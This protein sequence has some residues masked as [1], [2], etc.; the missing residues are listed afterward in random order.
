LTVGAF[1]SV[2]PAVARV[3]P[4]TSRLASF[5]VPTAA[6][7]SVVP[8]VFTVNPCTP[9]A[10]ASTVLLNQILPLPVSVNA[11]VALSVTGFS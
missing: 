4:F 7:N 2:L 1:R 5:V 3:S 10:A 9:A 11:A 8:S 6:S